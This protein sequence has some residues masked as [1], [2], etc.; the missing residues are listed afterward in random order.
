MNLCAICCSVEAAIAARSLKGT[1][2]IETTVPPTQSDLQCRPP[3]PPQPPPPP[4]PPPPHMRPGPPPAPFPRCSSRLPRPS[5]YAFRFA[6]Q[7]AHPKQRELRPTARPSRSSG[8]GSAE[9]VQRP[10]PADGSSRG[11][12]T[13]YMR[14]L[15]PDCTEREVKACLGRVQVGRLLSSG[16]W[17]GLRRLV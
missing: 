10:K 12:P 17:N 7:R 16:L 3:P 6:R 5:S 13:L 4:R 14:G 15:P 2:L 8:S 11:S 9:A 1:L